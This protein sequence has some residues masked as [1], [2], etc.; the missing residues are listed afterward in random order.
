MSFG[1]TRDDFS[2]S[3]LRAVLAFFLV[4]FLAVSVFLSVFLLLAR[5]Q[6][7]GEE[8]E[9]TAELLS[10]YLQ[11]G[12]AA[13]LQFEPGLSGGQE[14]F[15]GLSFLRITRNSSRLLLAGDDISADL[16]QRLLHMEPLPDGAWLKLPGG[17]GETIWSVASTRLDNGVLIQAGSESGASYRRYRQ[18]LQ[19]GLIAGGL[20]L[21]LS[22]AAAFFAVRRMASPL[23]RLRLELEQLMAGGRE[24]LLNE[25]EGETD[26]G[27]LYRQ[28]NRLI[29]QNRRLVNEMQASLDNVAHDLRTPMT[30]LRSVAE[31]GL[32][33][34]SDIN[35]LRESL[36]DCLEESERVLAML[37]IMMSVAEAETGTI[38]LERE[39]LDLA[40]S[41]GEMVTLYEYVAEERRIA[42]STDLAPGLACWADRTRIAQ[43][44]AN[45]LDN[46][47]KYGREGGYVRVETAVA[48]DRLCA[49]FRDNG[50]GISATEQPRIW[51]RLYRGDRSRSRQGLGLG[52]NFVRAIVAAHG[53][54]VEVESVLHKGSCFTVFLPRAQG[55]AVAGLMEK[56]QTS[57]E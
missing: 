26:R 16:F 27:K 56:S 15:G 41:I 13:P 22:L 55:S 9:R 12:I 11:R 52:L 57:G 18:L 2:A 49:R 31:F 36:A 39:R 33:E 30:R 1:L 37:R 46:A 10:T 43:V 44:W 35:K 5:H 6:L 38:R 32:R 54:T 14:R 34:D 42:L 50:M 24:Q 48:G 20:G 29:R 21:L 3:R 45:L 25:E 23:V 47:I 40:E 17:G 8:A 28:M 51:E 19:L 53:G 4:L 7:A